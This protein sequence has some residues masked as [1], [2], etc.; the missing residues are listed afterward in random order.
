MQ[1]EFTHIEQIIR[2]LEMHKQAM[3]KLLQMGYSDAIA[4]AAFSGY[5]TKGAEEQDPSGFRQQ[6]FLQLDDIDKAREAIR[7]ATGL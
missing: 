7:D 4:I 6:I 3:R 2:S 5:D 1:L